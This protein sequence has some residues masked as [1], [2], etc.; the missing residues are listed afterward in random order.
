MK[1]LFV[2]WLMCMFALVSVAQ[3]AEY[4]DL[5]LPSGTLWKVYNETETYYTHEEAVRQ[6]GGQLPTREQF[7]ELEM[8]CTWTWKGKKYVVKGRNGKSV[9]FPAEGN[10]TCE[11][12]VS[13]VGTY[14]YYWT[15]TLYDSNRAFYFMFSANGVRENNY[16]RCR[17][18]SVRL[19]K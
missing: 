11:G 5:G 13:G 19:V 2:G 12:K 10:C 14:G 9:S 3:E 7:K 18:L 8:Y 16:G 6:F 15:S 1:K 4:V 17:G